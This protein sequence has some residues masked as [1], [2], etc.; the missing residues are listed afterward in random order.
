MRFR[1][2]AALRTSRELSLVAIAFSISRS[3][4]T[5]WRATTTRSTPV[6]TVLIT[7]HSQFRVV[8]TLAAEIMKPV[9]NWNLTNDKSGHCVYYSRGST[10]GLSPSLLHR[11]RTLHGIART[12]SVRTFLSPSLLSSSPRGKGC[13]KSASN[14]R[15]AANGGAERHRRSSVEINTVKAD[16]SGA[17]SQRRLVAVRAPSG[18]APRVQIIIILYYY[19]R[20]GVRG[21]PMWDSRLYIL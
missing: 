10:L 20:G 1:I 12:F 2:C 17:L 3:R 4:V 8:T 11:R 21:A 7:C 9:H 16:T 14:G 18:K 13:I 6:P 15:E 5:I 19:T